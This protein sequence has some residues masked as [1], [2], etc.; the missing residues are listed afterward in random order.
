MAR[1]RFGAKWRLWMFRCLSSARFSIIINGSSKGFFPASRSVRQGDSL[2]P[3]LFTQ[4]AD[5]LS[6]ILITAET[7]TS[8][9]ASEL[10]TI[11]L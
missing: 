10:V 5:S 7:K 3:C 4:A 11:R 1:K 8:S 9:M 6:Q 2:P